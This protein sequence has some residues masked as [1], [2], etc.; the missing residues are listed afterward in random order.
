[1]LTRG[2]VLAVA[3]RAIAALTTA[4]CL[5]GAPAGDSALQPLT[6]CEV[7]KDLPANDGKVIPVLGRYSFRRDGR[8]I[9]E[10]ACGPKP[11]AG[12]PELPNSIRLTDDAKSG[13][14]PPDVFA[15]DGTVVNRKLK[16]VQEQTSLRTFRFG[17]PDY[18]RWAVVYGRIETNKG[19]PGTATL[20]YRG[21]GVILYLHEN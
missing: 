12:E 3:L 8:S 19:K 1:M 20:V 7:L 17:T 21:D 18:D 14:K 2:R 4:F 10:E 9:N 11:A 6:V 16:L 5:T 13:P 15:L